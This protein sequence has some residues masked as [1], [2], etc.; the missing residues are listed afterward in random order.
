MKIKV[1]LYTLAYRVCN[2]CN[3][4]NIAHSRVMKPPKVELKVELNINSQELE[5]SIY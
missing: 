2:T 1:I 4:I 5:L 3:T